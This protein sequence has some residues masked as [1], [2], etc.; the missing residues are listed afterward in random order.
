MKRSILVLVVVFIGILFCQPT[1]ATVI[2]FDLIDLGSDNFEYIYTIENDTLG[3]PIEQFLIWFDEQLY[4]NLQIAKQ[5]PLANDW[6]EIILPSSG[7]GV[8]LGYDALEL[9]GGIGLGQSVDGFSV[10]FDWLGTGLPG[11]QPFEIINPLDSQP[12][13]FGN[14]MPEP[15]T[16]LLF[17]LGGLMLRRKHQARIAASL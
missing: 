7:F 8:P 15:T 10:S 3:V 17:A 2:S 12:I 9:T 1:V 16:I 4:D 11:S 13:D 5:T 6:N 14:T